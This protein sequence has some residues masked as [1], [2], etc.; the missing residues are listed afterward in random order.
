MTSRGS[1]EEVAIDIE[2]ND[3]VVVEQVEG[4]GEGARE[5][6]RDNEL[7]GPRDGRPLAVLSALTLL[8]K[9]RTYWKEFRFLNW[10]H[11][12]FCP[13]HQYFHDY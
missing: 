1:T 4:V 11:Y 8:K 13:S 12:R 6:I 9:G 5:A 2:S 10:K 3:R 7:E